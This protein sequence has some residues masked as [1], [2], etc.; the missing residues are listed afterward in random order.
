MITPEQRKYIDKLIW[1]TNAEVLEVMKRIPE[2]ELFSRGNK[3]V[4]K[5]NKGNKEIK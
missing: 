5:F 4:L 3:K 2:G 1:R